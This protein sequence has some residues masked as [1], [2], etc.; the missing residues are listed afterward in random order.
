MLAR[1]GESVANAQGWL[2]GYKD[3]A[4]TP[5]GQ[6]QARA[7][8]ELLAP[9]PFGRVVSSDLT[10]AVETARPVVQGR[11]GVPW[12]ITE[13]LRERDLGEWAEVRRET[14]RAS[15]EMARLI[16][17]WGR[18]PGGESHDDLMRRALPYLAALPTLDTPSL[19]VGHG[20]LNRALLG[21][22]DGLPLEEIGARRIQNVEW[23]AIQVPQGGFLAMLHA[24]PSP[25]AS[26][27]P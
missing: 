9:V 21:L 1:H 3:V 17:W 15:G 2:A 23:R 18:P 4:L 6:A 24:L 22:F 16:S 7:L 10:R 25:P 5:T 20:G 14:L 19:L 11:P 8:A 13:A 26:P 12:L 27:G